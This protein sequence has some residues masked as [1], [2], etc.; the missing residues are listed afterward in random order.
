MKTISRW[1]L[2]ALLGLCV[3]PAI[4]PGARG[5]EAA[6]AMAEFRR[7]QDEFN[8][9]AYEEREA[10]DK[11]LREAY[12]E[13]E[14]RDKFNREAYEEREARDKWN[15]EAQEAREAQDKWNRE[16]QQDR[17]ARDR[18]YRE[19]QE[20]QKQQEWDAWM[21][22]RWEGLQDASPQ[23]TQP[24]TPVAGGQNGS[25]ARAAPQGP[26]MVLNS[27]ALKQ[28]VREQQEKVR[29]TIVQTRLQMT[30]RREASYPQLILNP[31]VRSPQ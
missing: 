26:V 3:L 15:R 10:R 22:K 30:P 19:A 29:Q 27:F 8:R 18:S 23:S 14:A 6:D 28:K 11:Y 20:W 16:V 2:G 5:D 9:Q 13:R 21:S 17:D 4:V 7:Q 24:T 1:I 25:G 31:F 12:A